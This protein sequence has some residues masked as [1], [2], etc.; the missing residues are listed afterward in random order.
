M[1][2]SGELAGN[3]SMSPRVH[4]KI[5]VETCVCVG[6]LKGFLTNPGDGIRFKLVEGKSGAKLLISP[7]D[8]A[9][10][11]SSSCHSESVNLPGAL[12]CVCHS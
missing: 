7:L 5:K 3:L 9:S 8:N 12:V 10:P 1:F 11:R 4:T 2:E 6:D